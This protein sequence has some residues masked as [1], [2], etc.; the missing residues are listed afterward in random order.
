MKSRASNR[1]FRAFNKGVTS[2]NKKFSSDLKI[3]ACHTLPSVPDGISAKLFDQF[4]GGG[5][6]GNE[7]S[8]FEMGGGNF[9]VKTGSAHFE[10]R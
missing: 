8:A 5:G 6:S 10:V 2:F 9:E 4:E 3:L 7:S 1:K